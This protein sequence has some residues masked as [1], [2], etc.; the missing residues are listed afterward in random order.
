MMYAIL[1][2][3]DFHIEDS[4]R[5]IHGAF[6]GKNAQRG[7]SCGE[8]GTAYSEKII[9]MLIDKVQSVKSRFLESVFDRKFS[10][11]T[12]NKFVQKV[13][14]IKFSHLCDAKKM[15]VSEDLLKRMI[16]KHKIG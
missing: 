12:I 15:G 16:A 8:I 10:E 6:Y 13:N 11:D 2:Q 3:S 5:L 9:S 14:S 1:N 7:T 4:D